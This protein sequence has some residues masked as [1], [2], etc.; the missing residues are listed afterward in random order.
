MGSFGVVYA[1]VRIADRQPVAFKFMKKKN[2]FLDQNLWP[3]STK[4]GGD[5]VQVSNF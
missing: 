3:K 4:R 1:G 5:R 2:A